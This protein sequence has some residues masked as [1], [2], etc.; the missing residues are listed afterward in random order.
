MA[1]GMPFIGT[2]KK[3]A[4][5]A[6][7]AGLGLAFSGQAQAADYEKSTADGCASAVGAYD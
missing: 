3:L 2:R 7:A 5:A 6:A 4:V 1:R